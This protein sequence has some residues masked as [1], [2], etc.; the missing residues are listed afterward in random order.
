LS[1]RIPKST[2]AESKPSTANASPAKS[3][4]TK[5]PKRAEALEA[6]ARASLENSNTAVLLHSLISAKLGLSPSEEKTLAFLEHGPLTAGE[7]AARTGLAAASITSLVDRLEHKGFA[8]RVRDSVDRRRVMVELNHEQTAGFAQIFGPLSNL[9]EE[10]LK[11]YSA[12]Q[13]EIIRHFLE[14]ATRLTR[15]EIARIEDSSPQLKRE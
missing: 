9:L 8:R 14:R 2:P 12:E 7:I 6:A 5:P 15:N 3:T 13:L 1:S 4:K 11:P 10:L